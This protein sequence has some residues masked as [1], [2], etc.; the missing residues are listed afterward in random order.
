MG[1]KGPW[2]LWP[3]YLAG[4]SRQLGSTFNA[5]YEGLASCRGVSE[6]AIAP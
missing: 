6:G 5:F 1:P 4:N 3:Q 2:A